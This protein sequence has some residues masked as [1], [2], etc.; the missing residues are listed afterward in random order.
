MEK[1]LLFVIL[2][3][4]IAINSYSQNKVTRTCADYPEVSFGFYDVRLSDCS[5]ESLDSIYVGL[6]PEEYFEKTRRKYFSAISQSAFVTAP[7]VSAV[8]ADILDA[9]FSLKGNYTSENGKWLLSLGIN[10]DKE[11]NTATLFEDKKTGGKFSAD[12]GIGKMMFTRFF[13][14]AN[15]K[16]RVISELDFINAKYRIE[17]EKSCNCEGERESTDCESYTALE[18]KMRY[19]ELLKY[20]QIRALRDSMKKEEVRLFNSAQWTSYHMG[21]ITLSGSLGGEKVYSAVNSFNY[22]TDTVV[23]NKLNTSSLLLGGNYFWH[24]EHRQV[25]L[26]F[27][28]GMGY[29]KSNNLDD[30]EK[31]TVSEGAGVTDTLVSF[32]SSQKR[33]F[34]TKYDAYNGKIQS[35]ENALVYV[36]LYVLFGK[37]LPFGFHVGLESRNNLKISDQSITSLTIG[38]LGSFQKKDNSKSAVTVELFYRVSGSNEI[39][40]DPVNLS[41]KYVLGLNFGIPI[42]AAP[43]S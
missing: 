21:W 34:S 17:L 7:G 33:D 37:E 22:L 11:G 20:R 10:G 30:L 35:R 4:A 16:D 19:N 28:L 9:K 26:L 41:D 18:S 36:N 42:V 6:I 5:D 29:E 31:F 43:K 38:A 27:N 40:L 23:T 25:N 39:L 32:P 12:L 3:L 15:E 8:S 24:N 1:K 14:S 2:T 13:Y